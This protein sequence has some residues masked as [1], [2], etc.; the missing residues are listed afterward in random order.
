MSEAI[1]N[2]LGVMSRE[3]GVANDY[4]IFVLRMWDEIGNETR[5]VRLSV[6]N[7]HT[8]QRKGFTDWEQM[9]QFLR[10]QMQA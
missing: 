8:G 5:K 2:P 4:Q 6:E 9:T 7:T 1:I 10:Q 3:K